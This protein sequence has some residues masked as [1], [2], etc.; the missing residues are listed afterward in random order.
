MTEIYD[1]IFLSSIF[2]SDQIHDDENDLIYRDNGATAKCVF[3][4]ALTS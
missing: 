1:N 4:R 3:R 2:L